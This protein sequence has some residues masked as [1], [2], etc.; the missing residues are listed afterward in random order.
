M[1]CPITADRDEFRGA[2]VRLTPAQEAVLAKVCRTN[3]GGVSIQAKWRG[4]EAVPTDR[5]MCALFDKGLIQGKAGGIQQV[6][7]TREGLAL[8][9]GLLARAHTA[10][11]AGGE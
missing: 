10:A 6:V 1:T 2:A 8:Y 3:G 11:D 9:R 5:V 7:H 4:D